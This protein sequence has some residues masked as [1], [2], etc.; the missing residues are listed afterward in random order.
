M[1]TVPLPSAVAGSAAA[2]AYALTL[3]IFARTGGL[4]LYLGS[5]CLPPVSPDTVRAPSFREPILNDENAVVGALAGR[6]AVVQAPAAADEPEPSSNPPAAE[7]CAEAADDAERQLLSR[8]LDLTAALTSHAAAPPLPPAH[9]PAPPPLPLS[10]TSPAHRSDAENRRR[11]ADRRPGEVDSASLGSPR[12]PVA[13][14]AFEP[15]CGPVEWGRVAACNVA[16]VR[17]SGDLHTLRTFLPEVAVG[18]AGSADLDVAPGH[19]RAF[20]LAQL[21]TQYLLHCGEVLK[22]HHAA[23]EAA[24]DGLRRERAANAAALAERR[25]AARAARREA[26]A[27]SHDAA[28]LAAMLRAHNPALAA[29]VVLRADGAL[30]LR[31][32]V[33]ED[34]GDAAEDSA[35]RASL[36]RGGGSAGGDSGGDGGG[37]GGGR[38]DLPA[39]VL[40]WR[41]EQREREL[42]APRK[43]SASASRSP[44]GSGHAARRGLHERSGDAEQRRAT[45]VTAGLLSRDDDWRGGAP[46]EGGSGGA[47][48]VKLTTRMGA[49]SGRSSNSSSSSTGGEV[50]GSSRRAGEKRFDAA[51]GA[52]AGGG[53][54]FAAA[55]DVTD[56]SEQRATGLTQALGE[57]VA[58][59][60]PQ[61]GGARQSGDHGIHDMNIRVGAAPPL[62]QTAIAAL[63]EQQSMQ[64]RPLASKRSSSGGSSSSGSSAASNPAARNGGRAASDSIGAAAA[65]AAPLPAARRVSAAAA[66]EERIYTAERAWGSPVHATAARDS[67]LMSGVQEA[68]AT[69][70]RL[71]LDDLPPSAPDGYLDVD[72]LSLSSGELGV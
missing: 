40:R 55:P 20:E 62:E 68:A 18:A 21:S 71:G 27:L 49:R 5:A 64:P 17:R 44:S 15:R 22:T 43:E 45:A 38:G 52:P 33:E 24:V 61:L 30:R 1:W 53:G 28:A 42:H 56:A 12:V 66:G 67:V 70:A 31:R 69:A 50:G 4:T 39:H 37:G 72:I 63:P 25:R 35:E 7:S 36:L 9:P 10:P 41:R 14:F 23:M 34:G 47:A 46:A 3:F 60:A 26:R 19:A 6:C 58:A 65:A 11:N 59:R 51:R 57:R 29:R 13:G 48:D 8:L 54:G 32:R 2:S 16:R